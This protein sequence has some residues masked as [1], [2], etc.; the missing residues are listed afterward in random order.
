MNK[1]FKKILKCRICKQTNLKKV[2]DLG[3]QTYTGKFP[4]NF[5]ENIPV[6]PLEV[7]FCINCKFLQ[8]S[9]NFNNQYM[10]DLDYGYESGINKTMTEHLSGIVKKIYKIKKLHNGSVALDIASNDGTLLNAYPKNI[11][12]IGVDPILNRFKKNYIE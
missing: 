1:F 2:I 8:L 11:I 9:H 12:K 3:K 5:Y 6:T 4:R 7:S 10:Y